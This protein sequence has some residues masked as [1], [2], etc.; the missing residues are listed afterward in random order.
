MVF[1]TEIV[2]TILR[3]IWKQKRLQMAKSILSKKNKAGIKIIPDF[4]IYY[5]D[6]VIKTV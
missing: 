6:M 1:F 5:K 4:K 3:F 2:K